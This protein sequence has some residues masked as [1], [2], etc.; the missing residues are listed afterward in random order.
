MSEGRARLR[1]VSRNAVRAQIT[2]T[3]EELFLANGFDETTVEE[4]AAEVGMSQRSFFRYFTS[5]DEVVL[6]K[7]EQLGDDLIG[8]LR[9]RPL[10]ESEWDSLR[11]IFDL[12]VEDYTD[13]T[14]GNESAT[15][16]RIIDSSPALLAGYLKHLD[17]IQQ[18]LTDEL[19]ARAAERG[20]DP[21]PIVLR[22]MVGAAFA[23]LQAATTDVVTSNEVDR[24]GSRLDL[25]MTVL[26]PCGRTS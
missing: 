15:L 11:R 18:H 26:R 8:Y 3:A 10:D 12:M 14:K 4:I 2:K 13:N 19:S 5:K 16:Q 24:I 6:T 23:C 22:A 9:S 17:Q 1:E 21:D 25:T 20:D 7:C